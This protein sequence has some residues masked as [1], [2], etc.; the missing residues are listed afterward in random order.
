MTG[1]AAGVLLAGLAAA[2]PVAPK[3]FCPNGVAG[4]DAAPLTLPN[5]L[6]PLETDDG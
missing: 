5:K 2:L 6:A 4:V 3:T 1:A